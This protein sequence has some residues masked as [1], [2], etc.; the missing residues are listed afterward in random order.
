VETWR[1]HTHLGKRNTNLGNKTIKD[2]EYSENP[3]TRAVQ[4]CITDVKLI[5][6][7]MNLGR[8]IQ[9]IKGLNELHI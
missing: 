4:L 3:K 7:L 1:Y 5:L 6:T 2:S 9:A 8:A